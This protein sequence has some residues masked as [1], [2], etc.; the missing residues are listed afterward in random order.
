MGFRPMITGLLR[1][2]AIASQREGQVNWRTQLLMAVIKPSL[3]PLTFVVPTSFA[4]IC[5][6]LED[7]E[8]LM[9]DLTEV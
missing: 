7:L 4:H 9:T 2:K 6:G 1:L 8:V 5:G 3:L